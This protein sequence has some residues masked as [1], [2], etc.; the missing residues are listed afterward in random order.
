MTDSLEHYTAVAI[1]NDN[2]IIS[3]RVMSQ[4]LPAPCYFMDG[5]CHRMSSVCLSV[6]PSVHQ[7]VTFIRWP[8]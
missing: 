1:Y 2:W 3:R 4:F 6:C 5:W 8:Y 7:S